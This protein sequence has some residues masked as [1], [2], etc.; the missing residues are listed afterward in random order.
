MKKRRKAGNTSKKKKPVLTNKRFNKPD[1]V[2]QYVRLGK[3][4]GKPECVMCKYQ[5]Y[6]K[7]FV[8]KRFGVWNRETKRTNHGCAY[9]DVALC[10]KN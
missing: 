7:I 5:W 2:H 9:C 1:E 4:T 10:K 6:E 8:N 3:C